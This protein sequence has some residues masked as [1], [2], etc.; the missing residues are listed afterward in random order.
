MSEEISRANQGKE[1][2]E[3]NIAIAAKTAFAGGKAL[4]KV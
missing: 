1:H 3:R 2:T 4:R